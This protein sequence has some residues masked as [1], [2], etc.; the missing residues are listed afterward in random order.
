MWPV[1][2]VLVHQL[3]K[4][5]HYMGL[6][7]SYLWGVLSLLYSYLRPD[8]L[9]LTQSTALCEVLRSRLTTLRLA[10]VSITGILGQNKNSYNYFSFFEEEKNPIKLFNFD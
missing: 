3:L 4:V 10:H 1:Q 5:L 9:F 6:F 7:A 2:L 8:W